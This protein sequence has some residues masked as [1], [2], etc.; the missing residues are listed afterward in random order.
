MIDSAPGSRK[1]SWVVVADEASAIVFERENSRAPLCKRFA[2]E[3]P[4]A[5]KKTS[6]RLADRGGRSFDSHGAGRHTLAREKPRSERQDA[7]RFAKEIAIS[8]HK[9]FLRGTC[10]RYALIAAPR[11]LGLLRQALKTEGVTEPELTIDKDMVGQDAGA[12]QELLLKQ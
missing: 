10:R 6:E 5:R 1:T 7:I 12:I 9:G 4:S 2:L 8:I 3:N 11:F